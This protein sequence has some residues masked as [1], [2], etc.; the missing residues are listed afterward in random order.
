[1]HRVLGICM[2]QSVIALSRFHVDAYTRSRD[3]VYRVP[4]FAIS[5]SHVFAYSHLRTEAKSSIERWFR[6]HNI[7]S[8]KK[9][10]QPTPYFIDLSL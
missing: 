1:M 9:E 8:K 3:F 6:F 7:Q 2:A 10:F 4:R 5:R